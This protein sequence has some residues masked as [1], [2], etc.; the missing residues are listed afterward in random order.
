MDT[1]ITDRIPTPVY[2]EIKIENDVYQ[3]DDTFLTKTTLSTI[4]RKQDKDGNWRLCAYYSTHIGRKDD[5][6]DM[7]SERH[8]QRFIAEIYFFILEGIPVAEAKNLH[9]EDMYPLDKDQRSEWERVM[10]RFPHLGPVRQK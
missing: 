1:L 4:V 7:G 5:A 10:D 9:G 6:I 8:I 2:P 3:E